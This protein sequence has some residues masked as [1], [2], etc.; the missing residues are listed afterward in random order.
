MFPDHITSNKKFLE[1]LRKTKSQKKFIKLI[2]NANDDQLLALV[3]I[4]FNVIKGNLNIKN[5]QRI[6]LAN[7]G[8]YYRT[9]SR[10]RSPKAAQVRIQTGGSPTL[11]G[12]ILAPVLGALAQNLLDKALSKNETRTLRNLFIQKLEDTYL[13][14]SI[15]ISIL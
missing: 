5:R 8:D 3:D 14:L 9:I 12:A 13:I 1:K 2:R 11:V 7:N 4:C 6:K 10:A 15:H